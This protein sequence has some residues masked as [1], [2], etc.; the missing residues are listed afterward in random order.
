MPTVNTKVKFPDDIMSCHMTWP[1]NLPSCLT[2]IWHTWLGICHVLTHALRCKHRWNNINK[3]KK[4][5]YNILLYIHPTPPPLYLCYLHSF[6]NAE[7]SED[8]RAPPLLRTD[9]APHNTL[10]KKKNQPDFSFFFYFLLETSMKPTHKGKQNDKFSHL[11][12]DC[13]QKFQ[14]YSNFAIN[15]FFTLCI[16]FQSH[17][18]TRLMI[19]FY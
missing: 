12:M 9:A 13:K 17:F 8:F 18:F 5:W 16:L 1:R 4:L 11:L 19:L 6:L 14:S 10:W 3:R 2:E 15:F 7:W